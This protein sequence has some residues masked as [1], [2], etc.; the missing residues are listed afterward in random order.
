MEK[1]IRVVQL[2]K[3]SRLSIRKDVR[4]ESVGRWLQPEAKGA[5]EGARPLLQET[6]EKRPAPLREG[7]PFIL[8]SEL[9]P[10][11]ERCGLLLLQSKFQ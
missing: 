2:G 6:A 5:R 11:N 8:A 4:L 9:F 10:E 7:E 3:P 1:E